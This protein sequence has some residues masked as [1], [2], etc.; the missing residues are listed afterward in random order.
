MQHK[1]I[2]SRAKSYLP[3]GVLVYALLSG[4]SA[5]T[6]YDI[7]NNAAD[8]MITHLQQVDPSKAVSSQDFTSDIQKMFKVKMPSNISTHSMK[9][10]AN[11]I[12]TQAKGLVNGGNSYGY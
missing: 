3:Y 1:G 5:F 4:T 8:D 11:D 2:I 9:E 6:S 12:V 10:F 7:D